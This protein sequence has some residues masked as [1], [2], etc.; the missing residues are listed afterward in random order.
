MFCCRTHYVHYFEFRAVL[1]SPIIE[2]YLC[3]LI[4]V[5]AITARKA[6]YK[7]ICFPVVDGLLRLLEIHFAKFCF[8]QRKTFKSQN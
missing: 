8:L 1:T 3:D 6:F 5:V 7:Y 2:I 4:P